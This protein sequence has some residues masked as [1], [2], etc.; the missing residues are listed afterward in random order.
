MELTFLVLFGMQDPVPRNTNLGNVILFDDFPCVISVFRRC[1]S[2][3][4]P[5]MELTSSMNSCGFII[6]EEE[7]QG[8]QNECYL[9]E[10]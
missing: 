7:L 8:R 4:K 5:S 10:Y 2:S 1:K 6:A 9:N 3:A